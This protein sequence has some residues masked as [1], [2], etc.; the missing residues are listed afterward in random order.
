[1]EEKIGV[2]SIGSDELPEL[3][4]RVLSSSGLRREERSKLIKSYLGVKRLDDV[5]RTYERYPVTFSRAICL[6]IDDLLERAENVER[7]DEVPEGY[8]IS[9]PYDESDVM[10]D[11]IFGGELNLNGDKVRAVI[12]STMFHTHGMLLL[13]QE[14]I[15]DTDFVSFSVYVRKEDRAFVS[16]IFEIVEDYVKHKNPLRGKII[17]I[18]G[19]EEDVG[20]YDWDD[21]AIPE[22]F[23]Q[24]VEENIIW[25]IKYGEKMKAA[26]LR[27]PRGIMLEG[28]RGMGK[29]LLS[30]IIANKVKGSG[31][32]IKVKPSDVQR[33]GWDYIF[34]VARTLEPCVL[35]IEDIESL[36]PSRERLGILT[37][38]LTDV[39]DYLD[40][41]ENRGNV[42]LLASTNVPDMVDFGLLDRPGRID[43]RLVF[44]PSNEKDFGLE[45]KKKV[46]EIHLRGHKLASGLNPMHLAL[47][48]RDVPYTGSHIMELVH[49]AKLEALRRKGIEN[50]SEEEIRDVTLTIGDFKK[51]R[52]RIERIVRRKE[53]PEVA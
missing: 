42:I 52:E 18:Y 28:Q 11:V 2:V 37:D 14:E 19:E 29:T 36:A 6:A 1:M 10:D 34:N 47:M 39:L 41:M 20:E 46:F 25:P 23:V 31:T 53:S 44:D 26:N 16:R 45:W 15:M 5:V 38:T 3:L 43:R 50:L 27:I 35:Y 12:E 40:G 4:R 48:I 51:A 24:E 8:P 9:Q 17:N 33:L 21:I 49:T 30:K 13:A 7:G 22:Y 32:F